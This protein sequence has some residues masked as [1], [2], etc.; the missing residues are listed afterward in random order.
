MRHALYVLMLCIAVSASP[1]CVTKKMYNDQYGFAENNKKIFDY[2]GNQCRMLAYQQY[3]PR[4]FPMPP[5][6]NPQQFQNIGG[7]GGAIA[8]GNAMY[9]ADRAQAQAIAMMKNYTEAREQY[10]DLCMENA[11]WHMI[12]VED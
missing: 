10:Y 7:V 2:H 11:G 6:Y 1:G 5:A 4:D 8:R 9:A 3:P 12:E